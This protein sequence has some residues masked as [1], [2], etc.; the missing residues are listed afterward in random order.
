MSAAAW[1]YRRF[2]LPSNKLVEVRRV[3]D[4]NRPEVVVREVN[5]DNELSQHEYPLRLDFLLQY[6]TQVRKM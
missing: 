4:G 5:D 6:A 1:L 2:R 3:R